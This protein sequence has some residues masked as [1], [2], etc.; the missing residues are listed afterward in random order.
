MLDNLKKIRLPY[1]D[2]ED[3]NAEL[4]KESPELMDKEPVMYHQF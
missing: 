2:P 4:F 3:P 1:I